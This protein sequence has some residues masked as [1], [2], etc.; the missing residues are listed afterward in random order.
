M[1]PQGLAYFFFRGAFL[2]LRGAVPLRGTSLILLLVR[3]TSV[4]VTRRSFQLQILD[5]ATTIRQAVVV[6]QRTGQDASVN[7]RRTTSNS[8]QISTKL[9]QLLIDSI[10]LRSQ[11]R[12]EQTS[13]LRDLRIGSLDLGIRLSNKARQARD[14]HLSSPTNWDQRQQ[15][16]AKATA[17]AARLPALIPV[18]AVASLPAPS[19]AVTASP[20]YITYSA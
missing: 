5:R 2:L 10:N 1:L 8:S 19:V 13:L 9:T 15:R 6:N 18:F 17:V 14:L 7:Q 3:G 4:G 11:L 12:V 16:Q 20:G